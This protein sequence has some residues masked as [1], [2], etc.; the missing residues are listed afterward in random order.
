MGRHR[1][2]PLKCTHCTRPSVGYGLCRV[3]KNHLRLY[4]SFDLPP[5]FVSGKRYLGNAEWQ[6]LSDEP[7]YAEEYFDS[8]ESLYALYQIHYRQPRERHCIDCGSELNRDYKISTDHPH[9]PLRCRQCQADD[10]KYPR[11]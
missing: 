4:G 11:L 1:T 7:T 8:I 3:H 5:N 2:G 10:M 6:S 9:P